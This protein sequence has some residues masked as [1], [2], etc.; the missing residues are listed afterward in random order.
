MPDRPD[1]QFMA[2]MTA[3]E[4]AYLRSNDP[5]VRSGFSG[6]RERWVRERSP[7]V[8]AI[9]RDGSFLD[10]GC[11]NGLL[12]ADVAAWASARG[13]HIEPFGVDLGERLI[14]EARVLLP[15]LAAN[16]VAADAWA[17]HPARRWTFVYSLLDLSPDE[18]RPEWLHHL[19]GWV[20]PGGRLIVGSYG[21]ESRR[22]APQPVA[23]ILKQC[24]LPVAGDAVAGN[25]PVTRFA[26]TD[27]PD[28]GTGDGR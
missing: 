24:D 3:L 12:A 4:D 6:G 23:E 10:V 27:K 20:T 2:D 9:H 11:A 5:V 1:A 26:W 15:D 7:I 21:S 28:L 8:E 14:G 25:P 16:F 13:H 17:W 19:L 18:L 22:M